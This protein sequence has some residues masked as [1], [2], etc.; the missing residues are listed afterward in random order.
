MPLPFLPPN[1]PSFLE[2][3]GQLFGSSPK[4]TG[5]GFSTGPIPSASGLGTRQ[6][7]NERAGVTQRNLIHWMIPEGPVIQMYINPQSIR[8]T[9]KKLINKTQTKGGYIL[10]Y[11]GEE[12]GELTITGTTGT[13]G[14]EGINVLADLYRNEQVAFDPYALFLAAKA[15]QDAQNANALDLFGAGSALGAGANVIG[16]LLGGATGAAPQPPSPTLAS[17]AFTVEMYWSGEVY[18]GYFTGFNINESAD[19]LGLFTY[20]LAFT[21]T[22]K[23]GLRQNFLGWHRSATSGPSDSGEFGPPHSFGQLITAG[24]VF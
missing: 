17:L 1:Q 22:Q 18:R 15:D 23:R 9:F 3:A 16:S 6:L 2:A 20:D 10:Q 21:V 8:Y 12:L 13:S 19:Q 11:W 24:K 4:Q 14:I 7:P 5:T